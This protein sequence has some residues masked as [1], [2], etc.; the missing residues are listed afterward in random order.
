MEKS[1]FLPAWQKNAFFV[2]K[3]NGKKHFFVSLT[4]KCF[5]PFTFLTKKAFFCQAGKKMLFSIYFVQDPFFAQI[6]YYM[7]MSFRYRHLCGYEI[8]QHSWSIS[9]PRVRRADMWVIFSSRVAS[10]LVR[11]IYAHMPAL[12]TC[13]VKMLHL[14]WTISCPHACLY[15]KVP[16]FGKNSHK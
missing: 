13:V 5:F 3:V 10:P 15:G 16:F 2:R 12:L 7:R 8:V 14:C 11:K 1:I 9:T 4:K 6:V